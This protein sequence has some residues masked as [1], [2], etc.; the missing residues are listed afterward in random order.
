[1]SDT[2][3]PL[4]ITPSSDGIVVSGEV[5]ASTV[6]SLVRFITPLPGESGAVTVDMSGVSFMDSSGLRALVDAHREA[7]RSLR[8]LIITNPSRVVVRL[9]DL[10]GLGDV[11]HVSQEG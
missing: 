3:V 9:V 5:D 8:R 7:E 10:S 1:M 2:G 11:L 4:T 6:A